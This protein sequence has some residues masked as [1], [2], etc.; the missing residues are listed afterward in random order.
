MNGKRTKELRKN[1]MSAMYGADR[2]KFEKK[3]IRTDKQFKKVFRRA[4]KNYTRHQ[5]SK[6]IQ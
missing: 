4:K 1:V 5:F 2:T 3:A 6:T